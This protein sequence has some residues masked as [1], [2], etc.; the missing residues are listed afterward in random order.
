M[1]SVVSICNIALSNIGKPSI[2]DMNEGSEEARQ[3]KTH[4]VP[5]RDALLQGF[6]W[7]F[8]KQTAILAEVANTWEQKWQFAYAQPIE[9][10]KPIRIMP[11]IDY[12]D[13]LPAIDYAV[14]GNTIFCGLSPATLEFTG[15]V[16]DVNMFPQLFQ[17]ALSW[18]LSAKIAM[19]L[20]RDQSI[21]K[22]AYQ[23]AAQALGAATMADANE[24]PASWEHPSEFILARE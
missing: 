22:D 2:S 20:T 17:D 16:E 21:R 24:E 15:R 5:T 13:G 18:A 4:Y 7:L 9:C 8:A 14:R 3:C 19:P 11:S 23:I 12:L 1:A 10:L 6:P